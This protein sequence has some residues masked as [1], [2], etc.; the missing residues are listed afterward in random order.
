MSAYRGNDINVMLASHDKRIRE[1]SGIL[2][3]LYRLT[4]LEL[5]V[6]PYRWNLLLTNYLD[7]L[8][9]VQELSQD[10]I[11]NE[12]NN[13]RKGLNET[14]MTFSM[15]TRGLAILNPCKMTFKVELKF[16]NGVNVISSVDMLSPDQDNLGKLSY[17]Y[18]QLLCI[19]GKDVDNLEEE[20]DNY[21]SNTL[22]REE[23]KG[24][25]RGN[26]K[27]N[28]RRELPGSNITW[29]VFKKGLRIL[30]PTE[31]V[32]SLVLRWNRSKV[33]THYLRIV[34]PERA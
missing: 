25:K 31:T 7:K 10:R 1:A 23:V 5:A 20:I 8:A 12:R 33:T 30:A 21:L 32:I 6:T 19:M 13:L 3:R 24:R 14:D 26:D 4:L 29:E 27:G 22:V 9:E 2:S 28:L 34:T 18:R 11:T 16:D 15:L 17:L